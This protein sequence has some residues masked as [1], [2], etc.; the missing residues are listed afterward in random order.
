MAGVELI[1]SAFSRFLGRSVKVMVELSHSEF[2][3]T[4]RMIDNTEEVTV[5]GDTF[6]PYAFKLINNAQGETQGARLVLSNIDRSVA[7]EIRNA[8]TNENIVCRV[9]IAHLEKKDGVINIERHDAGTF[10]VYS[11]VV[12]KDSTSM[13]LNL[14]ISINYNLGTYRYTKN[15]F[16]NLYL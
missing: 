14:R 10:E 3:Q 4:Y 12:T 2:T 15:F 8:T 7:S 9:W 5:D 13:T 1:K 11:P 16:P 6:K